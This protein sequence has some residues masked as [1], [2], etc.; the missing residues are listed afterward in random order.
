MSTFD[1]PFDPDRRLR[2]GGCSCGQHV[3]EAEHHAAHQLQLQA[4]LE[5][6]Q[7]RYEGVVA[8]AVMRAVFPQ[9]AARRRVFEIGGGGNGRSRAVAILPAEDQRP[10]F[11]RK[12]ARW[13][14]KTSRSASSRSPARR[15]S[16]WRRRW[17]SMPRTGSTSK[18]SRP[19]AGR[20]FA[21]RPS[22]RNTT[23]R[24]CCRRCRSPSPWA[25]APIRCPTPCPR[26]RT[27]TARRSR[28]RSSTRTSATRRT[29]R[30]SSSP[31]R[32]T[33]PCTTICC[34]IISPSMGSIP[35][36]TCRSARCRRRKWSPTCAPTTS[37]AFSAPI[38]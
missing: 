38:R 20:S 9:D 33:T 37:T 28:W 18:S 35:T 12:A 8:S 23:R 36:S 3:S 13:R 32:S 15:R 29:G 34:A 22:T 31:C 14:R 25:P 2:M 19:R 21:T 4:A 5:S 10:K 7:K 16:S 1:N 11:S 26:S 6:E 17:G 27:S 24:T 30:A